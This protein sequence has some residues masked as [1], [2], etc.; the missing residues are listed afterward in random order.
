MLVVLQIADYL[1]LSFRN[2]RKN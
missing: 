1:L 2:N